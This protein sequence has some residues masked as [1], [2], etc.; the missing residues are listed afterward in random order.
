MPPPPHTRHIVRN[1]YNRNFEIA[2][3]FKTVQILYNKALGIQTRPQSQGARSLSYAPWSIKIFME[4][5]VV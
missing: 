1:V 4:G 5:M 3:L 2:I